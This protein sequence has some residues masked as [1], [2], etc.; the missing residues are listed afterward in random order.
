[1]IPHFCFFPRIFFPAFRLSWQGRAFCQASMV[2]CETL[3]P[4]WQGII[5]ARRGEKRKLGFSCFRPQSVTGACITP[6]SHVNA[7]YTTN[8]NAEALEESHQP[9]Q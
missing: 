4:E 2:A 8:T 5:A 7:S 3:S 6:L 9:L 1:V